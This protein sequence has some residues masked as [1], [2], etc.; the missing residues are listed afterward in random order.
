MHLCSL[1]W[2]IENDITDV[3]DLSFTATMD[4]FGEMVEYELKPGGADIE[5]TEDNKVEYV[6]LMTNFRFAQ[7]IE[8]QMNAFVTGFNS[9]IPQHL[10]RIFDEKELEVRV[11]VFVCHADLLLI[12]PRTHSSY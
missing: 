10:I 8:D 4:K 1:K 7:N 12:C 5:V 2:I 3:L 11:C 9:I 6:H